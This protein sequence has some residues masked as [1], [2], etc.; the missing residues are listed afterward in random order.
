[1]CCTWWNRVDYRALLGEK[2]CAELIKDAHSDQ[3]KR[4]TIEMA[5]NGHSCKADGTDSRMHSKVHTATAKE[6][7]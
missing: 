1:M 4:E 7:H 5:K 2:T 6:G 3:A